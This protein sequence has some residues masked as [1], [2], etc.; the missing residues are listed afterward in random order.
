MAFQCGVCRFSSPKW[1]GFC[2]QCRGSEPLVESSSLS[3]ALPVAVS[4]STEPASRIS[5]GLEEV[6]RVLGGGLVRGS[7]V[8]VGGAPGIGKSTLLGQVGARMTAM[9]SRVLLVS[10]EESV[11][12]VGLRQ[13]RLGIA[14]GDVDVIASSDIA[15]VLDLAHTYDVLV[16]DSIQTVFDRESSGAAGSV[17]Q[18][19]SCADRAVRLAKEQGVTVIL[20]GHITKEGSLAGPKALE[21]LVDVVLYFEPDDRLGLRVLR[22]MKN[23]FGTVWAT[24]VFEMT[25]S[26]LVEIPDPSVLALDGRS[27]FA[28][29]SVIMPALAGR[30]CLLNEV[31]ALVVPTNTNAPPR[32]SSTGVTNGR[33]HQILAVLDRRGG[34]S[35]STAEVYVSVMGGVRTADPA[36]DLAI[37]AA[38]ISSRL[39]VAIPRVAA[40]GEVGLTGEIRASLQADVR[41]AE[42]HRLGIDSVLAAPLVTRVDQLVSAIEDLRDK[43]LPESEKTEG[44][45]HNFA[46]RPRVASVNASNPSGF[47]S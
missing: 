17:S 13:R 27:F 4:E 18:V 1:M 20:V 41:L 47:V 45:V 26:G 15:S 23:R 2:P 21:H 35:L 29:G 42:C 34:L 9:G 33:L 43:E 36:T 30:R 37:A 5:T 28:P 12:Q 22:G 40:F 11:G 38:I 46:G 16:I 24:G 39:D 10:A 8:L 14:G 31:Q 3:V 25:A 44:V 32:R 6:D 7:A 19:R